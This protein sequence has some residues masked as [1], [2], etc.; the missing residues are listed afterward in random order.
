[1][2]QKFKNLL[3]TSEAKNTTEF[4]VLPNNSL[5]FPIDQI[6]HVG[7]KRFYGDDKIQY[8]ILLKQNNECYYLSEDNYKYVIRRLLELSRYKL[9]VQD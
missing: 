6:A 5:A 7:H 3:R 9:S 1:M 2:F 4:I 8:R